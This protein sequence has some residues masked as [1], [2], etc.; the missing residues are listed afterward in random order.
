M[1]EARRLREE[2]LRARGGELFTASWEIINELRDE[3]SLQVE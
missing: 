2:I 3:R 1:V